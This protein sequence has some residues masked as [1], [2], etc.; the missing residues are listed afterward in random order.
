[1]AS[2]IFSKKNVIYPFSAI[3]LLYKVGNKKDP[4]WE[5][6]SMK[7]QYATLEKGELN[8]YL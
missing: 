2:S 7:K 3:I 5:V 6:I 1:M 4:N 8:K